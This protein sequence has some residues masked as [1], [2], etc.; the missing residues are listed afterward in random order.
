MAYTRLSN[1]FCQSCLHRIV[2]RASS[3][4][5]SASHHVVSMTLLPNS[6]YSNRMPIVST[7]A[8][9]DESH[10]AATR[11]S[12]Y[13]L[14]LGQKHASG[15]D[16]WALLQYIKTPHS[17]RSNHSLFSSFLFLPSSPTSRP[18]PPRPS[19][20]VYSINSADLITPTSKSLLYNN[21]P[22]RNHLHKWI[23]SPPY[24][25]PSSSPPR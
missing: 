12:I 8:V 18:S 14:W 15:A 6:A 3:S 9:G 7:R 10:Y 11:V 20:P 21:P 17:R 1:R 16:A 25:P 19:V 5:V 13:F 22:T 24:S 4:L 2:R 23:P